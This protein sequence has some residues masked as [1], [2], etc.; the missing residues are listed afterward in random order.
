MSVFLSRLLGHYRKLT[1]GTVKKDLKSVLD[2]LLGDLKEADQKIDDLVKRVEKA[3]KESLFNIQKIGLVRFNPFA[4]T[5]GDQSFCLA[6]LDGYDSGI[7][8][9]SLHSRDTT[10]IYTKPVKKG[11]AA[12]YELSEEEKRAV[13]KAKRIK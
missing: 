8:V 1:G 13:K 2:K 10:R 12:G 11:R 9:S 5:G 4:E 3:E 7:V 6:I